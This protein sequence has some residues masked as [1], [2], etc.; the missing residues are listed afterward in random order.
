MPSVSSREAAQTFG[1]HQVKNAVNV[2]E[3]TRSPEA[4]ATIALGTSASELI[5]ITNVG[6]PAA[7][8]GVPPHPRIHTVIPHP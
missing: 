4:T 1:D 8:Q 7:P 5:Q 3:R 2:E 6:R